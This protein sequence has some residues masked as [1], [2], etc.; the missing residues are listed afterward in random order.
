VK[1]LTLL[2]LSAAAALAYSPAFRRQAGEWA[3]DLSDLLI[4]LA[5][6]ATSGFAADVPGRIVEEERDRRLRWRRTRQQA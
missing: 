3:R 5:L 4:V 2:A 1:L 6:R